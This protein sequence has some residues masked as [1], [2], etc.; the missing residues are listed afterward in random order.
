MKIR[1]INKRKLNNINFCDLT[2]GTGNFVLANGNVV[3]HNSHITTL[4]MIVFL[5]LV[6]EL[7]KKGHIF[8]AEMP[9]Y[10]AQVGKVFTPFYTDEDVEKFK[11]SNPNVKLQR[12]K[13]LGEMNPDQLKVCLLDS[14]RRLHKIEFPDNSE[15]LLK[16]MIDADL[17]RQLVQREEE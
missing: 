12:Y 8:T 15:D 9:L 14:S 5:K 1:K 4:L 6:P 3:I 2:T 16:L 7:I 13:G 11:L 10:G 17:K